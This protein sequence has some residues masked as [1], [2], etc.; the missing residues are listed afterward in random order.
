MAQV[1]TATAVA[2]GSGRLSR[3]AL[4]GVVIGPLVMA[5]GDL[6]HPQESADVGQQVAIIAGHSDRWYLAHLLLFVGFV[7]YIPGLLGLTGVVAARWPRTGKTARVLVLTGAAGVSAIFVTE[8]VA[9]RLGSVSPDSTKSLL[10]TFFSPQV[11]IPVF[12][13][14]LGFFVGSI[15]FAVRMISGSRRLRM[16]AI[17]LLVGLLS[18][19]AEIAASQ[20]VLSQVGNVLVWVGSVGLAR[21]LS[22]DDW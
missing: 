10:D 11:A 22:R 19:V 13:V 17:V 9:G 2:Q 6:I 18:I 16:P 14:G 5:I 7:L 1:Q 4:I 12:A 3:V 15:M 20:V 8:M 21:V